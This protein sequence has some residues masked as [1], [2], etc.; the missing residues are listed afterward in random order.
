MLHHRKQNRMRGF[1]YTYDRL[2]FITTCVKDRA[3]VFGDIF[4]IDKLASI[5]SIYFPYSVTHQ[6]VLNPCGTIAAQ[7]WY[8]LEQQYPYVHLHAF[9]V[10]PN[11]VHGIIEINRELMKI[12]DSFAYLLPGPSIK[13]K[14]LSELIGAYKTTSSKQIHLLEAPDGTHP[15]HAFHWQRS[16]HDHIIRNQ[17]E[18][19]QITAYIQNNPSSWVK[20]RFYK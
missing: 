13:I 19:D 14:A 12:T 16:F 4:P 11:H 20:D 8:W 2:Y 10:M 1:D 5:E 15:Y 6:M 17:K 9:I 18:Y 3:C 7:Q